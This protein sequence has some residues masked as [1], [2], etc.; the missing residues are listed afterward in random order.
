MKKPSFLKLIQCIVLCLLT[1]TIVPKRVYAQEAVACIK[2]DNGNITEYYYNIPDAMNGSRKG[3]IHM[4]ADW[5][6]GAQINI[7]E[8]TT[9][10]IYMDGHTIKKSNGKKSGDDEGGIFTLHPNSKLYLYG[11]TEEKEFTDSKGNK[12][13]SGG[14]VTGGYAT[15]G[16][17]IYMKKAAQL[18]LSNVAISGSTSDSRGGGIF[19]AGE[20]DEIYMSNSHIDNNWAGNSGGGI[21]SLKDGT[22]IHM[23]NK[24]TINYNQANKTGS[25][26]GGVA[27]N[28]SWFSLEGDGT[29]EISYNKVIPGETGIGYGGGISVSE[30]KFG[31]NYGI[32]SGVT[33]KGNFAGQGAGIE[34]L[35]KNLYLKDVTITENTA[36]ERAG[37]VFVMYDIDIYLSGDVKIYGNH[38][39]DNANDDVFLQSAFGQAYIRPSNL[40][41]SSLIGIR[42]ETTGDRLVAKNISQELISCFFLNETSTYHIAYQSNDNEL[43][44]RPGVTTYGVKVNGQPAGK[45][46]EGTKNITVIDN[47]TDPNK[48]FVSWNKIDAI[49]GLSDDDW[50]TRTISFTMPA[51]EV[52]LTAVYKDAASN[53]SLDV[54]EITLGEKL[55]ATATFNWTFDG[56][57]SSKEVTLNW[58]K[59]VDDKYTSCSSE[60]TAADGTAYIFEVC[61]D[62]TQDGIHVLSSSIQIGDVKINSQDNITLSELSINDDGALN[63]RSKEFIVGQDKIIYI[64][65]IVISVHKGDTKD[66][67]ISA[68]YNSNNEKH[69]ATSYNGNVYEINLNTIDIG[70]FN[71]EGLFNDDGAVAENA[72]AYYETSIGVSTTNTKINLNGNENTKVVIVVLPKDTE[73]SIPAAPE[74]QDGQSAKN[75]Q[76]VLTQQIKTNYENSTG[77]SKYLLYNEGGD[78]TWN[79]IMHQNTMVSAAVNTYKKVKAYAWVVDTNGKMSNVSN[80]IYTLDNNTNFSFDNSFIS[81][82]DITIDDIV[83]NQPLPS[84]IDSIDVTLSGVKEVKRSGINIT[85]NTNGEE[86]ALNNKIYQAKAKLETNGKYNADY[87]SSLDINVN[88]KNNGNKNVQAYIENE[89]GEAIL[90]ITFPVLEGSE[91]A[92]DEDK[93]LSYTLKDINIGDY[94][95]EISYEEAVNL[96]NNF[97]Y[98]YLPNVALKV[99]DNQEYVLY[100]D[101][102][103][104][105]VSSFDS[106]NYNDQEIVLEGTIKKP[107]Y[108]NF[109]S[110]S[111]KFTL[112]IK[113]KSKEGYVPQDVVNKVVTCEEYMKSNDWTWSETKKACVYRVS[114]TSVQ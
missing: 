7:V 68:I 14:L 72:S 64:D 52:N 112:K 19:V 76:N 99:G 59:K 45:Y 55:P 8:G 83:Y 78:N 96:N 90:Y 103:Y 47:N 104:N 53:L 84:T 109:N 73:V 12:V 71:I 69:Y 31:T 54:N 114:N 10:I 2:D 15:A 32:I 97:E 94:T 58:Y 113:V 33:I 80:R 100:A 89:D 70:T 4:L 105:I 21:F 27:F 38:R 93:P 50:K 102:T 46:V 42:T 30:K 17:A 110:F 20:D 37:G 75:E 23:S 62:I 91:G 106:A 108:I 98:F 107:S 11:S 51:K 39:S 77:F 67:V 88:V 40:S 28:N 41:S 92:Y 44:Q 13:T 1:F 3:A 101:V 79:L 29:C 26:G 57:D 81:K 36:S 25:K 61:D 111:N 95:S 16:G 66:S 85:W 24:S 56:R 43:W 9:S 35:P 82:I 48:I 65:P 86:K 63:F 18:H 87:L 60:Q 34:A 74:L 5:D 6:L 49:K 22:H